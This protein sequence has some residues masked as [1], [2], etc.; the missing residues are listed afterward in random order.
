[1]GFGL[2]KYLTDDPQICSG[3]EIGGPIDRKFDFS[4]AGVRL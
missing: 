3:K 4:R 1:V 2:D